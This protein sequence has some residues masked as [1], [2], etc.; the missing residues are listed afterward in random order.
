MHINVPIIQFYN[1]S[2]N[3]F[4]LST[5]PKLSGWLPGTFNQRV[6]PSIFQYICNYGS[7]IKSAKIKTKIRTQNTNSAS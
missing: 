2:S 5:D 3:I 4:F 7:L 6:L 1:I